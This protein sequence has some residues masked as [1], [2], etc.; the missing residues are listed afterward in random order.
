MENTHIYIIIFSTESG[1]TRWVK[2]PRVKFQHT[3]SGPPGI[4]NE[5]S[6]PSKS[7]TVA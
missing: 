1:K 2:E 7:S 5:F 6:R 3:A 4:R